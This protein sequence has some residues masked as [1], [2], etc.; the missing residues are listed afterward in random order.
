[1]DTLQ[2]VFY[3]YH[4]DTAKPDEREAYN[5]LCQKLAAQGLKCFETW[6]AGQ[7][8]YVP[9]KDCDGQPV[10]LETKDLF[11]NQW[12]TAPGFAG[13]DRGWRVFDWAQ[14]YPIDFPK[15]IKRGHWIEQTDAMREIRRNTN[16]C[17]YCGHKERAERGLVFC[18]RCRDNEYLKESDLNLTRM[19]AVDAKRGDRAELT[20]AEK[21]HLLPLYRHAQLHGSTERGKRRIAKE[22]ADVEKDLKR[23][24]HVAQTKH[25]GLVW[26][27]DH[28]VNTSNVIYH[29]H[30]DKFSFGWR[31]PCD[32]S[33]VSGLLD[34]ISEFP[35]SYEIKCADGRTLSGN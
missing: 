21:A 27:M 28:G 2:T 17:G 18:D 32:A 1:M 4:F 15:K 23:S 24:L 35:F 6:G 13:S 9:F 3:A 7:D 12:N 33:F 16:A 25:D 11:N 10:A 30:T 26:L 29:D 34:I 19:V 5:A 20:E 8:Y 31:Q 22:R 14:D